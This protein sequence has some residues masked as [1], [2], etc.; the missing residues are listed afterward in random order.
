MR[1]KAVS[2]MVACLIGVLTGCG[3]NSQIADR[4]ARRQ[5]REVS[6]AVELTR[7][8]VAIAGTDPAQAER[9]LLEAVAADPFNGDARNN[10]GVVLLGSGRLFDA[11]VS[12]EAARKLIPHHPDPRLN[13]GL[14]FERAGRID[15]AIAAYEDAIEVRS[16]HVPSMQALAM[17]M[18][19][20]ARSDTRTNALLREIAIRGETESWRSWATNVLLKHDGESR[21]PARE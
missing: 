21:A 11:A 9:L 4:P 5:T 6:R 12:F 14:T 8:A 16:D 20:H 18:I 15:D 2:V 1:V 10:L 3:G 13:L 7:R 17:C 19:R